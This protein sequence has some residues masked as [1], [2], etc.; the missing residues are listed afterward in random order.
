MNK[1]ENDTTLKPCPLC[2]G[3][4]YMGYYVDGVD[5]YIYCSNCHFGSDNLNG[6]QD[7]IDKWNKRYNENDQK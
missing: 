3:E 2:G 5:N 7:A 6:K 4:A 1:K